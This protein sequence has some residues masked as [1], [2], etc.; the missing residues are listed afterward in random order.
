MCRTFINDGMK[1]GWIEVSFD[2]YVQSE[3]L[4]VSISKH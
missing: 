3:S 2:I 1:L 4:L